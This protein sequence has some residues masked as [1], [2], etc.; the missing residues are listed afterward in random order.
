MARILSRLLIL[1]ACSV[2]L[3]VACTSHPASPSPV[4]TFSIDSY[5]VLRNLGGERPDAEQ[6]Y[7]GLVKVYAEHH[8]R[9]RKGTEGLYLVQG[10]GTLV[11]VATSGQQRLYV[12]TA[13]HVVVPSPFIKTLVLNPDD[14]KRKKELK[15]EEI[16]EVSSRVLVG[17]G[18]EPS[19]ILLAKTRQGILSDVAFLEIPLEEYSFLKPYLHLFTRLSPPSAEQN[20]EDLIGGEVR[21]WGYPAGLSPQSA[22]G[23]CV[24]TDIRPAYMILNQALIGGYSGGLVLHSDGKTILGIPVRSD[25][26]AQQTIALRW[27]LVESLLSDPGSLQRVALGE[28]VEITE[29][30]IEN[31][32]QQTARFVYQEFYSRF[33]PTPTPESKWWEVWKRW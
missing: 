28:S 18:V 1:V 3:A 24:V 10:A 16:S 9:D 29:E 4:P 14:P 23:C 30:N 6:R 25:E 32:Q 20:M 17:I 11:T 2:F 22:S 13:R 5:P 8:V 26:R 27:D 31:K 33:V 15:F 7:I 19:A 12:V 21:V